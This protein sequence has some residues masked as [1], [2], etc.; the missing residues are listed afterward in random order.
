MF[1]EL[2]YA[3]IQLLN[4]PVWNLPTR[5]GSQAGS[6]LAVPVTQDSRASLAAGH[7]PD[8]LASDRNCLGEG[9][10]FAGEFYYLPCTMVIM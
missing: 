9:K 6:V 4:G 3:D 10:R 8:H 7:V 2:Y 1:G 5:G